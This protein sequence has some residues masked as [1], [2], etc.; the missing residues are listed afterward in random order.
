MKH[1]KQMDMSTE[2]KYSLINYNFKLV[3]FVIAAMI[4]GTI[5][6][7]SVRPDFQTKQ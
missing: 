3:L 2:K 6:I 7:C 4:M 5:T 1:M